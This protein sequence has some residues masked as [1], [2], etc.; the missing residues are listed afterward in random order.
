MLDE[1]E[2]NNEDE[3]EGWEGRWLTP[4]L[5]ATRVSLSACLLNELELLTP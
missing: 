2:D 4:E 3:C 5:S 1:E